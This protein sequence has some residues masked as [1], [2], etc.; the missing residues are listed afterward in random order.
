MTSVVNTLT[1]EALLSSMAVVNS[2]VS[3]TS[4]L[5][6]SGERRVVT[7]LRYEGTNKA[8][9]GSYAAGE[10]RRKQQ[11]HLDKTHTAPPEKLTT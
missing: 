4:T 10:E 7:L 3:H 11:Q 5:K 2:G 8:S 6:E 1:A 9:P